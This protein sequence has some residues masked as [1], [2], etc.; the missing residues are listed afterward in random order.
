[1]P[2]QK[3]LMLD[4][5]LTMVADQ[6]PT[7][8]ALDVDRPADEPKEDRVAVGVQV[9][10]KVVGHHPG[11]GGLR[12]EGGLVVDR[13]EMRAL[14]GKPVN[15][16]LVRRPVDPLIS[17]CAHPGAEILA[18]MQRSS[19]NSRPGRKL[20]LRYFTPLSTLPLIRARY[21]PAGARSPSAGRSS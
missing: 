20:R 5:D 7:L 13:H 18:Q 21:A 6:D 12:P 15:R 19:T 14:D 16:V 4:D 9:H 3:F 17:H 2:S 8:A 10:E 11:V 1:M